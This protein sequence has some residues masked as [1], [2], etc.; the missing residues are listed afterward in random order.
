[1]KTFSTNVNFERSIHMD[2][3]ISTTIVDTIKNFELSADILVIFFTMAFSVYMDF[4]N[5]YNFKPN[6]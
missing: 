6:I 3:I 2:N 1:M 4:P 5:K